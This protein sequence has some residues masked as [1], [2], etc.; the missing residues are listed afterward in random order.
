MAETALAELQFNDDHLSLLQKNN[1]LGL[2][3]AVLCDCLAAVEQQSVDAAISFDATSASKIIEA[4][5]VASSLLSVVRT[6]HSVT[7][8]P[9]VD[10]NKNLSFAVCN[11]FVDENGTVAV[12]K[13]IQL[14]SAAFMQDSAR[15]EPALKVLL[16]EA[17]GFLNAV[18]VCEVEL[19]DSATCSKR[20][21]QCLTS[22][23]SSL[24]KVAKDLSASWSLDQGNNSAYLSVLEVALE[25]LDLPDN[26]PCLHPVVAWESFLSLTPFFNE[27]GP[28]PFSLRQK[29]SRKVFRIV[30]SSV[31]HFSEVNHPAASKW[32]LAKV[33]GSL[34]DSDSA[35]YASDASENRNSADSNIQVHR[36]QHLNP[37]ATFLSS[38]FDAAD[39]TTLS[40][41]RETLGHLTK[42][43]SVATST[44]RLEILAAVFVPV[45]QSRLKIISEEGPNDADAL[46]VQRLLSNV[47]QLIK[48]KDALSF[49]HQQRLFQTV[50]SVRHVDAFHDDTFR[51]SFHFIEQELGQIMNSATSLES[52][53]VWSGIEVSADENETAELGRIEDCSSK[54]SATPSDAVCHAKTVYRVF[55]SNATLTEVLS[56]LEA[57]SEE[58]ITSGEVTKPCLEE[59]FFLWQ[60]QVCFCS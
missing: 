23:Y 37:Y 9:S 10:A 48:N 1:L 20:S 44:T 58:F 45:L 14:I 55:A 19:S 28:E 30:E 27:A 21:L 43:L 34:S 32:R 18:G 6:F 41:I 15:F 35:F 42:V 56:T 59:I 5:L 36:L 13:T 26:V 2:C 16:K 24:A 29:I 57:R 51:F 46:I 52:L 40:V 22:L 12:E 39:E 4:T 54:T 31:A 38:A 53:T 3:L 33:N 60:L 25:A 8:K 50:M 17:G 49:C 7:S 11:M 47:R